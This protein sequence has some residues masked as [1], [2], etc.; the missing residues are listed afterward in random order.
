MGDSCKMAI[1][2]SDLMIGNPKLAEIGFG[3][4]ARGRNVIVGGFQGQRQWIDFYP[5]ADFNEAILN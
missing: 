4:E 3:E 1:I 5:N 2:S